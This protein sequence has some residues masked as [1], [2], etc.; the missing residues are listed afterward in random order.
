[1]LLPNLQRQDILSHI[2]CLLQ[3]VNN[4]QTSYTDAHK[5]EEPCVRFDQPAMK[6]ME[7]LELLALNQKIGV[8]SRY[9]FQWSL[10][11][12]KQRNPLFNLLS[13]LKQSTIVGVIIESSSALLLSELSL[14]LM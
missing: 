5:Y 12:M 2:R 4:Q 13:N 8:K 9:Y 7:R 14:C 6:K 10:L 1:M 11:L 3:I